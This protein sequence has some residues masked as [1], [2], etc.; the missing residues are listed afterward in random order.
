[1]AEL[2]FNL[3]LKGKLK[4]GFFPYRFNI[5]DNEDYV[6]PV[7]DITFFDVERMYAEKRDVVEKWYE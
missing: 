2:Q 6:G 7:P 3:E 5:P 4:K 1:M